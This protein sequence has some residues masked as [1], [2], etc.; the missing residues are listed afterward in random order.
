[1]LFRSPGKA[2]FY[3]YWLALRLIQRDPLVKCWY[4][5]K[6]ARDG[7]RFKGRAVIAVMRKVVKALWHVAQGE[8]FDSRKLFN[9]A[10]VTT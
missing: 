7:G 2:R 6:V 10:E 4:N 3:L 8:K 5:R 9:L 1:M